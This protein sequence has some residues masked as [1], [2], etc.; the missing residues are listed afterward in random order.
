MDH[1]LAPSNHSPLFSSVVH[2][3][4]SRVVLLRYR[5]MSPRGSAF[6]DGKVVVRDNQD[7]HGYIDVSVRKDSCFDVPIPRLMT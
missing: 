4:V 3:S 5:V 2:Q 6:V 7:H 1:P